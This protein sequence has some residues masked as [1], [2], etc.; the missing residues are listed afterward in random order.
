M[1]V[2]WSNILKRELNNTQCFTSL[3]LRSIVFRC[4]VLM[5]HWIHLISW[6]KCICSSNLF[7]LTVEQPPCFV[8]RLTLT[9]TSKRNLVY[10]IWHW[11][12]FQWSGSLEVK[13]KKARGL[14]YSHPCFCV[15]IYS[16][17]PLPPADL[18]GESLHSRNQAKTCVRFKRVWKVLGSTPHSQ[19]NAV[20]FKEVT[21]RHLED[22]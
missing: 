11:S 4:S 22:L 6:V 13:K 20:L 9:S 3:K 17:K 10:S 12:A 21:T 15:L 1:V 19:N 16:H 18:A 8:Q 2:Y 5:C 7:P 14:N